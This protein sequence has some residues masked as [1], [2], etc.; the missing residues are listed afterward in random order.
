MFQKFSEGRDA[1]DA[2]IPLEVLHTQKKA[3]RARILACMSAY[4]YTSSVLTLYTCFPFFSFF[5]PSQKDGVLKTTLFR[6][7]FYTRPNVG[8]YDALNTT[9]AECQEVVHADIC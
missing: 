4:S 3:T 9:A 5:S 1:E 7:K 8:V 2:A 6:W